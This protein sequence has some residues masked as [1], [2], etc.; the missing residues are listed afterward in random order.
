MLVCVF[1][2]FAA[3]VAVRHKSKNKLLRK[4]MAV[5]RKQTR[6]SGQADILGFF[7][8]CF[9]RNKTR[10]PLVGASLLRH[11]PTHAPNPSLPQQPP[12]IP[13]NT[14]L[15]THAQALTMSNSQTLTLS[16]R[17]SVPFFDVTHASC[18]DAYCWPPIRWSDAK[19]QHR[20]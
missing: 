5:S 20:G 19:Q 2:M 13:P 18:S 11:E 15:P 16:S 6:S 14:G 1:R 12:A 17:V 7:T 3:D 9:L 8:T 4:R 10:Y